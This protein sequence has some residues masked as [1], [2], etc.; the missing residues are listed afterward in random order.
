MIAVESKHFPLVLLEMGVERTPDE[1]RAMFV[2]FREVNRKAAAAMSRW[3]LV[4]ATDGVPNALERKII[5]DESNKF[6]KS[7]HAACGASVLVIS[8]GLVRQVVTFLQWLIPALSPLATA[9]TT[10]AA[11]DV[12]VE[13]LRSMGIDLPG[14]LA[15]GARQWFRRGSR[16][17]FRAAARGPR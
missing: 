2:D 11:I 7:D 12:A 17:P 5:A 16:M 8:N 13:R 14:D 3:V 6:S 15:E 9:P 4:A 10:D 1:I